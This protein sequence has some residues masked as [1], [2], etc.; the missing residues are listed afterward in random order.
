MNNYGWL[1]SYLLKKA[2]AERDYKVEWGWHRYLVRGK[3]FAA[4]CTPD[5]KYQPHQGREMVILKCEP[6]LAELLRAEY[7]DI[8]PGFYCDKANWN[9]VYLNGAVP[10][11]VLKELCDRSYE[12]VFSKLTKKVQREIKEHY[13]VL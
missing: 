2:G 11:Q 9:S 7:P 12:L 1:D 10:D 4:V 3:M 8:V 6:L 13:G 5:P